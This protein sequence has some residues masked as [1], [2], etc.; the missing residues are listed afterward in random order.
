M[1]RWDVVDSNLSTNF[2]IN[3]TWQLV[4]NVPNGQMDDGSLCHNNS[5]AE[6]VRH[7]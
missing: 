4:F 6:P 1:A 2:D 3:S 7:N 5:A